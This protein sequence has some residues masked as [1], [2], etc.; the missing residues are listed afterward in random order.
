MSGR[1]HGN[2]EHF[3]SLKRKRINSKKKHTRHILLNCETKSS[4]NKIPIDIKSK[5]KCL[6]PIRFKGLFELKFPSKCRKKHV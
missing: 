6:L 4:E 5:K 3:Y 1:L 2:L